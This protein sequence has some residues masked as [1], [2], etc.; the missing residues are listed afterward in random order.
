MHPNAFRTTRTSIILEHVEFELLCDTE[1]ADKV[2]NKASQTVRRELPRQ[3]ELAGG[4]PTAD[5]TF[6]RLELDLGDL[7]ADT[8]TTEWA[9]RLAKAILHE[10]EPREIRTAN[11]PAVTFSDLHPRIQRLTRRRALSPVAARNQHGVDGEGIRQSILA[12]LRNGGTARS[13]PRDFADF[14]PEPWSLSS[15]Q[16][17]RTLCEACLHPASHARLLQLFGEKLVDLIE[18]GFASHGISPDVPDIRRLKTYTALPFA[19]IAFLAGAP[20]RG[21]LPEREVAAT[22]ILEELQKY[23]RFATLP[24]L[25]AAAQ[26]LSQQLDVSIPVQKAGRGRP[27]ERHKAS[28]LDI[29]AP[30]PI[31]IESA[32]LILLWPLLP[33][34]L[35]RA[36]CLK[37]GEFETAEARSR[38]MYL[39]HWLAWDCA[40]ETADRLLAPALICG[41]DSVPDAEVAKYAPTALEAEVLSEFLA[42][43]PALFAH[44]ILEPLEI[45]TFFLQR[46]GSFTLN[47]DKLHW[48]LTEHGSDFL[49]GW[50]PWPLAEAVIPWISQPIQIAFDGQ[51]DDATKGWDYA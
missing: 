24:L 6:E 35:E 10:I 49:L 34:L 31:A 43:L 18:A 40:P 1:Q 27:H 14:L 11:P 8:P 2:M 26:N 23:L 12:Q 20:A 4:G 33:D 21:P 37:N 42:G 30:S 28:K 48:T 3:I 47:G 9:R 5:V 32:G 25:K 45:Q 15:R 38:A 46:E 13:A 50:L 29:A 7:F 17:W 22:P 16:W 44:A 19:L 41:L 36:G 39:L 51:S